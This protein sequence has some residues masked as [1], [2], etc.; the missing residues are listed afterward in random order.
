MKLM[1]TPGPPTVIVE[2][3]VTD[4]AAY[5]HVVQDAVVIVDTTVDVDTV[6]YDSV[7]VDTVV[8]KLVLV[9]VN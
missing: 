1:G 9:S 6:M 2:V 4:V 5:V 8:V 7:D 3:M